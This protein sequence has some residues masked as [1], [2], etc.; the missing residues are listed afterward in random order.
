MGGIRN[1]A[2]EHYP[3]PAVRNLDGEVPEG[4]RQEIL[5]VA[6]NL[7]PIIN[8]RG[9]TEQTLYFGIEQ[10]LGLQAAGNPMAGWRQRLGR[11]LSAAPWQRYTT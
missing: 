1:F 4:V 5:A 6:Y 8:G 2:G 3:G 7:L 10:M 11:D 9:L